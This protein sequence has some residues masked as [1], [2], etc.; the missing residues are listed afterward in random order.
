MGRRV[1]RGKKS[2]LNYCRA[3]KKTEN[4]GSDGPEVIGVCESCS[5]QFKST[6]RDLMKAGQDTKA[7]FDSHDC[8]QPAG[9][10][11]RKKA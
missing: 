3:P 4:L 10:V 7:Q 9:F 11:A 1:E 6:L 5:S 2:E 8:R